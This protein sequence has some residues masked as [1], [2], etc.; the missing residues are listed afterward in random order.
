MSKVPDGTRLFSIFRDTLHTAPRLVQS[1]TL[2]GNTRSGPVSLDLVLVT[3]K[4]KDHN[5]MG[6]PVMSD[7]TPNLHP[8]PTIVKK[9]Y[10]FVVTGYRLTIP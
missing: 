9:V 4:T 7:T 6:P 8:D 3:S 1:I 2:G 10:T 5:L